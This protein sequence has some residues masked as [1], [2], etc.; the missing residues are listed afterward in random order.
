MVLRRQGWCTWLF[1]VELSNYWFAA[2]ILPR[3][4]DAL[5]VSLDARL[6]FRARHT[7]YFARIKDD[8]Q[9][10]EFAAQMWYCAVSPQSVWFIALVHSRPCHRRKL[11]WMDFRSAGN[12][13]IRV[14][15]FGFGDIGYATLECG[16]LDSNWRRRDVLHENCQQWIFSH[17]DGF[18]SGHLW[19][20]GWPLRRPTLHSC[21]RWLF[22]LTWVQGCLWQVSSSYAM[23]INR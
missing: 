16:R 22:S 5:A 3:Q 1:K 23:W 17:W 19:H 2:G 14:C 8:A 15:V 12:W 4:M 7:L 9:W 21:A 20:L 10:F 6:V 18:Y 13:K 11:F